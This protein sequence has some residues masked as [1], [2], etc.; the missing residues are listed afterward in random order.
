[1]GILGLPYL[2][3]WDIKLLTLADHFWTGR[4]VHIPLPCC[5]CALV[6]P[7]GKREQRCKAWNW[8]CNWELG[9]DKGKCTAGVHHARHVQA[10]WPRVRV[11]KAQ[12]LTIWY[13]LGLQNYCHGITGH[14]LLLYSLLVCMEKAWSNVT[15]K[16]QLP[17]SATG[18][19]E[20][21]PAVDKL[22]FWRRGQWK[23]M[24]TNNGVNT[25]YQRLQC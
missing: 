10:R 7:F 2:S 23:K 6:L 19:C 18:G 25:H 9:R 14:C 1:M 8:S 21:F 20:D 3:P 12:G 11:S 17:F 15:G 4:G 5:I 13:G 16:E 24:V 22:N